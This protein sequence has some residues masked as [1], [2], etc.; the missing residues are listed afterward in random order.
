MNRIE[1]VLFLLIIGSSAIG[2]VVRQLKEKAQQRQIL[3]MRERQ[4]QEALRT[5]RNLEAIPS[6]PDAQGAEAAEAA[7][8]PQTPEERLRE[9]MLERQR[10]LEELRRRAAAQAQAQAQGQAQ[11]RTRA[12][13]A[14]SSAPPA[15]PMP[16]PQSRQQVGNQPRPAQQ[17]GP[18]VQDASRGGFSDERQRR[19][20]LARKRAEEQ[21]IGAAARAKQERLDRMEAERTERE[22]AAAALADATRRGQPVPGILREDASRSARLPAIVGAAGFSPA[23][24]RRAVIMS[25]VFSP[26]VSLRAE[27]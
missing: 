2:W 24:L 19:E 20:Q 18:V 1:L 13:Q 21:R 14:R 15:R 17:R 23:E 9:I 6:G 26:P 4:R 27:A 10:R 3:I 25:E 16:G 7:P 22:R 8:R 11:A 5:G 12:A